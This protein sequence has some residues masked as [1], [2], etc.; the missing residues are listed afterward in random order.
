MKP[1]ETI[2]CSLSDCPLAFVKKLFDE[3]V[4]HDVYGLKRLDYAPDCILD[5]GANIGLFSLYARELFPTAKIYAIEPILG[6]YTDLVFNTKDAN[7]VTW[8]I[9]LADYPFPTLKKLSSWQRSNPGSYSLIPAATYSGI[10]AKSFLE[11]VEEINE[12]PETMLI[13]SDC[14]GGEIALFSE[15]NSD[16]LRRVPY[17]VAE[18]HEPKMLLSDLINWYQGIS[19][20]HDFFK[21]STKNPRTHFAYFKKREN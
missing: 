5:I 16:F 13:K 20:T 4:T 21:E 17:I 11:I 3:I 15:V 9:A 14:E 1:M 6:N 10:V 18:I 7:I 8:Q 12:I 2:Q 19:S